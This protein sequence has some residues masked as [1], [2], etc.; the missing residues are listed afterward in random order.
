MLVFKKKWRAVQSGILSI[1]A[2][3]ILDV[4]GPDERLLDT[5]ASS[6]LKEEN[7]SKKSDRCYDYNSSSR[8]KLLQQS[9]SEVFPDPYIVGSIISS[10]FVIGIAAIHE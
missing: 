8:H 4:H 2:P 9:M 3:H 5:K 1:L 7:L 6:S 10:Q